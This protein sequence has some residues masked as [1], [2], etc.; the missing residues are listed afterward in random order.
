MSEG[1]PFPGSL[2]LQESSPARSPSTNSLGRQI[3]SL[4]RRE[5]GGSSGTLSN[6]DQR[7]GNGHMD[8]G[9]ESPRSPR[10]R[11]DM[12]VLSSTRLQL[13]HL[14]RTGTFGPSGAGSRPPTASAEQPRPALSEPPLTVPSAQSQPL[15][16]GAVPEPPRV[17]VTPA[18][19]AD[20]RASSSSEDT[21]TNE[22]RYSGYQDAR[23]RGAI[24][25][26]EDDTT[27]TDEEE[28]PRRFMGC[29]P[30]IRSRRVRSQIIRCLISGLFLITLLAIC[31]CPLPLPRLA[32][33][34]LTTG[35]QTSRSRSRAVSTIA[36][37]PSF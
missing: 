37:S 7:A 5:R 4:V 10:Y 17:T 9:V 15:V 27:S 2:Q 29:F 23:A 12:P 1:T 33:S 36:S 21:L 32:P 30:R 3:F 14:T 31:G 11:L 22:P 34:E 26:D 28:R 18:A 8:A 25:G 16:S 20:S 6:R 35:R 13:P 19:Q 24:I